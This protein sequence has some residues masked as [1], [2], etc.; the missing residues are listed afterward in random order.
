LWRKRKRGSKERQ[1]EDRNWKMEDRKWEP[2][3]DFEATESNVNQMHGDQEKD[4]R[5]VH[6][7][8]EGAEKK[9][10]AENTK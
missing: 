8:A 10:R 6:G 1:A 3:R 4:L 2:K 9:T 7:D 5:R